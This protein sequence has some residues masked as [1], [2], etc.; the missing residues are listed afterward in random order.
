MKYKLMG[1]ETATSK[2]ERA[3]KKALQRRLELICNV[4]SVMGTDFD[5]REIQ[6]NFTRN[7]P[8]NLVEMADVIS[9]IGH[10]LSEETQI[11]L[12]PIEINATDELQKKQAENSI[13]YTFE[14]TLD[15]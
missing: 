6:M 11:S 5:Y 10:L 2:K 9:K 8:S 12:L 1:L 3:F 13:E 7:I 4:Y 14:D 15:E